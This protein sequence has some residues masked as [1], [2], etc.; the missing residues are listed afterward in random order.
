MHGAYSLKHSNCSDQQRGRERE[1]SRR[2][3]D[4]TALPWAPTLGREEQ[5]PDRS[6]LH[7]D[8]T[9]H[10]PKVLP[11]PKPKAHPISLKTLL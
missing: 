3:G 9:K 7:P 8:L 2:A 1:H 6:S 5:E 10:S 4:I 11:T